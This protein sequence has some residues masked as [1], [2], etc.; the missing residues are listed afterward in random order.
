[1]PVRGATA[2]AGLGCAERTAPATDRAATVAVSSAV[3][4]LPVGD[5]VQLTGRGARPERTGDG[6]T[7]QAEQ[8]ARAAPP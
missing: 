2:V 3:S 8:A 1:M 5:T 6:Q 7:P 4:K